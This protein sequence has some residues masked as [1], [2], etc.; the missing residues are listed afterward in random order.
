MSRYDRDE[1]PDEI[2][3]SSTRRPAQHSGGQEASDA[4]GQGGGSGT[5]DSQAGPREIRREHPTP[6][7]RDREP[8]EPNPTR[9]RAY[10]LRDSEVQT[11][12]DI[13]AFRAIKTE[14]LV[15][16]RYDGDARRARG[17]L[18]HLVEEG[19][20]QR[21]TTYPNRDVYVGLTRKGR[22]YIERNR[23]ENAASRQVFYH[24]FVKRREARHDA[25]IYRL[26]QRESERITREGS[27]VSRVILDF[28]L[29]ASINRELSNIHSLP[30]EEQLS[31]RQ[32]IA[33][34]HGLTVVS[35][36][37]PLPDLRL[38][39]ETPDQQQTKV[40]LEVVSGEYRHGQIADKARAG[41][42]LYAFAE[43]AVRL[44]PALADP[45]IMQDILSL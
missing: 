21:R 23:P 32:E 5:S 26:Y 19:L 4:R 20:V 34:A 15:Q 8:R 37:I 39:Y 28:E 38:E 7:A 45:E 24:G 43:D 29:K 18:K 14:D 40:D 12:A 33:E 35:G 1:S 36:K 22:R 16:Y 3:D 41:F 9:A 13:G 31:R 10:D 6:S 25:A 30:P 44:R 17:D 42:T 27:R 11:L 2:R